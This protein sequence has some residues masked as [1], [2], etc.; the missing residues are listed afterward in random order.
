MINEDGRVKLLD[1]GLAKFIDCHNRGNETA[2]LTFFCRES[3]ASG[4]PHRRCSSSHRFW[5]TDL[6]KPLANEP[7]I[8]EQLP[9]LRTVFQVLPQ[10]LFFL[11]IVQRASGSNRAQLPVKL[12]PPRRLPLASSHLCLLLLSARMRGSVN[13][14]DISLFRRNRALRTKTLA[15]GRAIRLLR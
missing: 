3:C 12:M 11:L 13:M 6:A 4:N 1:F 14:A 8:R 5:D 7:K 2:V 10:L 9:A 15:A